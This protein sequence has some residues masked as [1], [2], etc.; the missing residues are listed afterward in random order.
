MA[1]TELE[2]IPGLF[3]EGYKCQK[4]GNTEFTEEHMRSALKKKE[5][6]IKL[7]VTRPPISSEKSL[8]R[9]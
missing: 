7:M 4:C 5:K 9:I 2:V 8:C 3:S 6:A 1:A